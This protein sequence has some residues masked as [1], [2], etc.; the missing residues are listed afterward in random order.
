MLESMVSL[1]AC[2]SSTMHVWSS[3]S[4]CMSSLVSSC[5]SLWLSIFLTFFQLAVL[6]L[7]HGVSLH[8]TVV[9]HS[10]V[11]IGMWSD[12]AGLS[13]GAVQHFMTWLMSGVE[14]NML[15]GFM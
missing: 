1:I 4:V 10:L 15:S 11:T 8:A 5:S 6:N 9:I 2:V 12:L 13:L 14:M 3:A 7:G